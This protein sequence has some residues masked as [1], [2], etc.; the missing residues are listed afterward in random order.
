MAESFKIEAA[1]KKMGYTAK[2]LSNGIVDS[3]LVY[4]QIE[5]LKNDPHTEHYR[6]GSMLNFLKG[7]IKLDDSVFDDII[8]ILDTDVDIKGSIYV[9]MLEDILLTNR[10]ENIVKAK[11]LTLGEWAQKRVYLLELKSKLLSETISKKELIEIIDE[12]N[13]KSQKIILEYC[14]DREVLQELLER[15]TFKKIRNILVNKLP[16]N[17][18]L[19]EGI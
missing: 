6:Y 7:S 12:A 2:W 14:K 11:V 8:T 3:K 18:N 13:P 4:E 15:T 16:P 1:L 19:S 17:I 10:Q 9:Y 5:C